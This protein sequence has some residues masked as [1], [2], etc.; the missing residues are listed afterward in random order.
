MMSSSFRGE[1]TG[2]RNVGVGESLTPL[3]LLNSQLREQVNNVRLVV[4]S[5]LWRGPGNIHGLPWME[6]PTDKDRLLLKHQL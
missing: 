6:N 1:I 4:V 3:S 5:P 2:L